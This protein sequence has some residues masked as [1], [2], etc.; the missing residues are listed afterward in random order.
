MGQQVSRAELQPGDLV[1]YGNP[2]YHVAIYIGDGRIVHARTFGQPLSVTSVDLA[3]FRF[4]TR[5][6]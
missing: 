1:F 6:L 5:I 2:I 4:G 3:D